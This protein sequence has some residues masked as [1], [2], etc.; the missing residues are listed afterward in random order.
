MKKCR[1]CKQPFTPRNSM[2]V[3]CSPKCALEITRANAAKE[4]EK[5][6]KADRKLQRLRRDEVKR[7]QLSWQH[8]RT[9]L[10]F[11]RMRVLQEL[12]WFHSRG[13]VP[14]CISCGK[15]LGGD[16]WCCGHFRTRGA[17]PELRYDEKNTFLQHNRRCNQMLSGDIEGTKTTH[18]YKKGLLLRFG[19]EEGQKIID[20][21]E[22]YHPAKNYTCEQLEEMRAGFNRVIRELEKQAA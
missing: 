14:T 5:K 15:P 3:V 11:N 12:D 7:S 8:K 10:S 19:D 13:L 18:G 2:T 1:H 4:R 20:Y 21:C 16:Q 22:S 17:S 9:Q 6:K